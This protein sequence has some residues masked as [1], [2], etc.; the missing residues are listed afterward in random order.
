MFHLSCVLTQT[1]QSLAVTHLWP[2]SGLSDTSLTSFYGDSHASADVFRLR[3]MD[4]LRKRHI[5]L[6]IIYRDWTLA[7]PYRILPA[8]RA[9]VATDLG[10][11]TLSRNEPPGC[12]ERCRRD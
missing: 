12:S 4:L 5:F 11:G 1:K 10:E 3:C 2:T 6:G 9:T 8:G 7:A